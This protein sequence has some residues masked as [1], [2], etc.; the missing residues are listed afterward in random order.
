MAQ[1]V[2]ETEISFITFD[3]ADQE[4]ADHWG[5]DKEEWLQYK[6]YMALEGKYFYEKVDPLTVMALSAT[7][8]QSRVHYIQKQIIFERKKIEKEVSLANDSWRIQQQMFGSERL[9]DFQQLP[10]MDGQVFDRRTIKHDTT[11]SIVKLA[12]EHEQKS[13]ANQVLNDQL[14]EGDEIW[15]IT[16]QSCDNCYEKINALIEEQP[17]KVVVISMIKDPSELKAWGEQ[18]RINT[19]LNTNRVRFELFDPFLFAK[20]VTPSVNQM[21]HARNGR[22][23]KKF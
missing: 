7:D 10:W 6:K 19:L 11:P 2:T 21:F 13:Q 5:L 9:V 20:G 4:Q 12:Q 17:L 22:V 15:L 16:D 18:S 8:S 14:L 23:L 1:N 3:Q